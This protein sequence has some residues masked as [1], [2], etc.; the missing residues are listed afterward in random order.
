MKGTGGLLGQSYGKTTIVNSYNV[1]HVEGCYNVGGLIGESNRETTILNS[2]NAGKVE[3]C[4]EK[5]FGLV[6][7]DV[8]SSGP[9]PA[10]Y[11]LKMENVYYPEGYIDQNGGISFTE[12]Q[13]KNGYVATKL[14]KYIRLDSVA[15]IYPNGINGEIWGQKAGVDPYPVFSGVLDGTMTIPD[16][17]TTALDTD[18]KARYGLSLQVASSSVRVTAAPVGS[19]YAAYDMQ[20]RVLQ[21][22]RVESANFDIA[23]PRAGRFLL[24]IGNWTG[25]VDIR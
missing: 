25:C 4:Y 8:S 3:G 15:K 16:E 21:K 18:W 2:Y 17:H 9:L 12:E 13:L 24:R 7:E 1:G 20:G 10:G 19:D 5:Y 11:S 14:H 22:G 6:G 23:F